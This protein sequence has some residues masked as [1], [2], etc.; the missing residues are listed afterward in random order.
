MI[1]CDAFDLDIRVW[2][3][4]FLYFDSFY[5]S[6]ILADDVIYLSLYIVILRNL[7]QLQPFFF[8]KKFCIITTLGDNPF[9]RTCMIVVVMI[10]F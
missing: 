5:Y 1:G 8:L 7:L 9:Q 4:F 2:Q 6:F 3:S 10:G